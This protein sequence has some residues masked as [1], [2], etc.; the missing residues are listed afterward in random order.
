MNMHRWLLFIQLNP[1]LQSD[2]NGDMKKNEHLL[3]YRF[4]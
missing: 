1:K 3:D 4:S 2:K